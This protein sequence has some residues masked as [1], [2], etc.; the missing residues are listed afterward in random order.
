MKKKF[1]CLILTLV[2]VFSLVPSAVAANDEATQ[3]AQTLYELGLFRGTGTNPDGT[4]IFDLDKTP[5]RNQAVIMLV[6]LLGKEQ[7]AL[8]G[9][10]KLPFTDVPKGSTAYPY[11]GYAYANGLTNGTTATT[12]SGGNPIRANQYI[13][14]VLRALGY[15]SGEDFKVSTAWEFSDQIGLTDGRYDSSTTEFLR[16]DI[17]LISESALS[18][19]L[20]GSNV[21]LLRKLYNQ[22]SA[23]NWASTAKTKQV[24]SM[25]LPAA[26]GKT[27]LSYN[28]AYAL[29]GKDPAIIADAVKTVGDV[30]QYMI[31][32]NFSGYAPG[33]FTP[34]Y[35]SGGEEWGFDP[36]GEEQLRQNYGTCC[37]GYVNMAL[38]LLKGDY[39]E[40]GVIRWMGGG[41][42][43]I[44][45]VLANGKYYVFDP[46][47]Y[48]GGNSGSVT[49][50]DR[51][52]DYYNQMPT[53]YPKSEM[54]NLVA[55]K[56]TDI[57]YPWGWDS[58]TNTLI[59]PTETK[60]HV[61]QLYPQNSSASISFADVGID[62][63]AW[64]TDEL[65]IPASHTMYDTYEA[66]KEKFMDSD[67]SLLFS[68]GFLA[69]E[70]SGF[71]TGRGYHQITVQADG[72]AIANYTVKSSDPS[73]CEVRV[74]ANGLLIFIPKQSGSCTL[75]ITY[76]GQTAE[77][78][79]HTAFDA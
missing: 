65:D 2:M 8:A 61:I 76:R 15:V 9:N 23:A 48:R 5:T 27:T 41:N 67:I 59:F 34:W 56:N 50:L 63:P 16:S 40:Q 45:Y 49:V 55:F 44:A 58:R 71:G 62:I 32:A 78:Y 79:Y 10:W 52:E 57:C 1:L 20:K 6:R 3:A 46:T 54:T 37:A 7:E 33:T 72:R 30:V 42:H 29:L 77:F 19:S 60:E 75:Y 70:D 35:R 13:A 21:M 66:L 68:N 28:D 74:E 51:L 53:D 18:T 43:T 47:E 17:A 14:F 11:I 12:Y 4:P 73:I 64:N 36:P 69:Q 25:G 26:I 31:A 38:Y 39:E 24:S 22:K